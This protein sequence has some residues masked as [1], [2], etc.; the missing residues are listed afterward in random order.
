M[1]KEFIT[2]KRL[3][4]FDLE[5]TGTNP[6]TDRIIT[7]SA[8]DL[9]G[10]TLDLKLNPGIPIPAEATAVN[11]ISDE[12]VS[13]CPS[14]YEMAGLIKDFFWGSD[15]AG[16]N[17]LHFDLPCL[18]AEFDRAGIKD[19]PELNT[20]YIDVYKM[21][22]QLERATLEN[23][24]KFYFGKPFDKAHTSMADTDATM[25]I[26]ME[27]FNQYEQLPNSI[28]PLEMFANEG[29]PLVDFAGK[30]TVDNAGEIVFNFGKNNGLAVKR[31]KDY[32]QWMLQQDTFTKNTKSILS[33]IIK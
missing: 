8:K 22:K 12:D 10:K 17:I 5:T 20:R 9:T 33:R 7:I 19:F 30:L 18:C 21:Y 16:Y 25:Q 24:F 1:K 13:M 6:D 3:I 23:C 32:V 28:E 4:F 15:I 2:N 31:H 14:F 26:F 27:M 29:K 11:G